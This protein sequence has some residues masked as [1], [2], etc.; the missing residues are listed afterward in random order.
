MHVQANPWYSKHLHLPLLQNEGLQLLVL[1]HEY[2]LEAHQQH[3]PN[4]LHRQLLHPQQHPES[5]Q[6]RSFQKNMLI[7]F[8]HMERHQHKLLIQT[9]VF[10]FHKT[11]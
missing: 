4:F 7:L 10:I 8:K 1:L 11:N 2:F 3:H 9:D 6:C 5:I